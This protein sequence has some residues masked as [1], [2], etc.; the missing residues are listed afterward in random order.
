MLSMVR[1]PRAWW[2]AGL[3]LAAGI[4]T[5][6]TAQQEAGTPQAGPPPEA[7]SPAGIP[8]AAQQAETEPVRIS[9]GDL[10]ELNVFGV[11]EMTQVV[12]VSASGSISLPLVGSAHIAG[13]SADEAETLIEKLLVEGNWLV[14]PHVSV[15]VKEYATQGASVLGEVQRPG[16]YPVLGSRRLFDLLSLAQGLTVRAGKTVTITRRDRPQQPFTVELSQDSS[17]AAESN[18]AIHPGDTIIVS[19]AGVVYVVGD[20]THPGGFVMDKNEGLTVLQAIALAEGLTSTAKAGQARLIR[21]TSEGRR[22]IPIPLN[23]ILSAQSPDL[24]LQAEDIVFVPSS[25]AK[26]AVRRTLESI[27]QIATGVIIYRR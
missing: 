17:R 14:N 13:L 11:P 7:L 4:L 8:A 22:E 12:R 23:K 24:S 6:A 25:V 15:F 10:V 3:M 16:V 9:S 21:N 18:V 5:S 19:K 1:S 27:V 26:R 20:V 2:L